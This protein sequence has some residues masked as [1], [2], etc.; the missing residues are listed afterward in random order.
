MIIGWMIRNDMV[1]YNSSISTICQKSR[2][3]N[4]ERINEVFYLYFFQKK[5]TLCNIEFEPRMKPK[6]EIPHCESCEARMT[7]II[8]A[9]P[10]ENIEK[11]SLHKGCNFH[12]TGQVLFQEGGYPAGLY[13]INRGKIKIYK[14]GRDGKKQ[15]V[16]LAKEGD[17]VG[18]RSLISGEP[19]S[20]SAEV[21]EDA[22]I[23]F[24]PKNTFLDLLKESPSFNLKVIDLLA[25]D[26]KRAEQ[27]E[28]SLAQKPVRERLAEALLMLK[29]F[30]GFEEDNTTIKGNFTREDLANIVG[31]ATE[32]IIR[33]LSELKKKKIIELKGK[34]IR[35]TDHQ[36]LLRITHIYD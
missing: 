3:F 31:T 2:E 5:S 15:V 11:L 36:A 25:L 27:K 20:A 7:S 30:F 6:F 22:A 21:I 34:K 10:K 1:R 35:I 33:L 9:L 32:T 14:T 16:R 13:C 23:C 17:V 8:N 24:I 4:P 18:Y 19:Y 29:E 12:K 26:L 28:L